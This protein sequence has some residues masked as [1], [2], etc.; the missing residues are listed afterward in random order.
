LAL[1]YDY[2]RRNGRA[3]TGEESAKALAAE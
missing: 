3:F 1:L 2:W